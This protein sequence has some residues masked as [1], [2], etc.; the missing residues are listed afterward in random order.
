MHYWNNG[1]RTSV[2]RG[3]WKRY[4]ITGGKYPKDIRTGEGSTIF[5]QKFEFIGFKLTDLSA[6]ILT[7]NLNLRLQKNGWSWT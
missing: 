4:G 2:N 1:I 3:F 7:R 6:L 5:S